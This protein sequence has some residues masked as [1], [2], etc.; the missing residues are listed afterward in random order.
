VNGPSG[1]LLARTG[2]SPDENGGACP[3]RSSDEVE[4]ALHGRR[5]AEQTVGFGRR[6]RWQLA[7]ACERAI[8]REEH[9]LTREGFGEIVARARFHGLDGAR[10]RAMGREHD[11]R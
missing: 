2:L 7:S 5:A 9:R 8:E 11:Y 3:C 6:R 1:Q 4:T 10:D